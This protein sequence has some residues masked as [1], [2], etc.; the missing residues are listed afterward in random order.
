MHFLRLLIAVTLAVSTG[1]STGSRETPQQNET[2]ARALFEETTKNYHLPS[3]EA[4]GAE[5]DRLLSE[6]AN[7]YER[8]LKLYPK[9]THVCAQALRSLGNVRASQGRLDDAVKLYAKVARDY[10]T[11]DW[12]IVSA[13]KSAGDLL[14]E[15]GRMPEATPY[16]EKILERFDKPDA[17]AIVK[18]IVR[19]SRARL[20]R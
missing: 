18:T 9:Q 3:A 16:Y 13:W 8:L 15:A 10:P 19:G 14:A 5:R 12:E 4:Q 7:G 20:A 11:E 2:N 6:A 17:T 1:C